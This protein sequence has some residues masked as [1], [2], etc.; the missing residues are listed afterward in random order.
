MILDHSYKTYIL[1]KKKAS[2]QPQYKNIVK[3]I[4]TS[5]FTCG[6]VELRRAG[7]ETLGGDGRAAG[8]GRAQQS[9]VKVNGF[10]GGRGWKDWARDALLPRPQPRP[11]ALT[12][13]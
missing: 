4:N 7:R 13:G 11:L 1:G 10:E 2:C 6:R 3:K 5:V 12:F 9:G 8:L